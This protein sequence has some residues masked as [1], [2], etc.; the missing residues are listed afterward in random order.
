M[1]DQSS[2]SHPSG[3]E[4]NSIR[5]RRRLMT[6][7]LFATLACMA[8]I[9]L[10]IYLLNWG[11][12][13]AEGIYMV[14]GGRSFIEIER[15]PLGGLHVRDG[16]L[17]DLI[18]EGENMKVSARYRFGKLTIRQSEFLKDEEFGVPIKCTLALNVQLVPSQKI[19]GDWDMEKCVFDSPIKKN[20]FYRLLDDIGDLDWESFTDDLSSIFDTSSLEHII[21]GE[22]KPGVAPLTSFLHRL[23]DPR[24]VEYFNARKQTLTNDECLDILLSIMQDHPDDPYLMPHLVEMS[25]RSGDLETAQDN[26]KRWEEMYC[27]HPDP[28]LQLWAETAWKT[29]RY[30]VWRSSSGQ[31]HYTALFPKH[32]NAFVHNMETIEKWFAKRSEYDELIFCDMPLVFP[33]EPWSVI[34]SSP[35]NNN[36]ALG[37]IVK[38]MRVRTHYNLLQGDIDKALAVIEGVYRTMQDIESQNAFIVDR[39]V[40][41]YHKYELSTTLQD[42][43]LNAT[44]DPEEQRSIIAS[45]HKLSDVRGLAS[46]ESLSVGRIWTMD[47]IMDLE[48][49]WLGYI[50]MKNI[51]R[52]VNDS[53]LKII[54]DAASL[55]LFYLEH[56]AWPTSAMLSPDPFRPEKS[57]V[58]KQKDDG[59]IIYSIGPDGKDDLGAIRFDQS[60]RGWD[61]VGDILIEIPRMRKYPFPA[62]GVRA[63]N[64][65]ELLEQF[66][67]GLPLDPFSDGFKNPVAGG[68]T[69]PT[70]LAILDIPSSYPLTVFS[71]GPDAGFWA[72]LTLKPENR[73]EHDGLMQPVFNG[74]YIES[75]EANKL[76]REQEVFIPHASP[77]LEFWTPQVISWDPTNG[78]KSQGDIFLTIPKRTED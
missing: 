5:K 73:Q 12:G 54:R 7:A 53:R 33:D 75:A 40:A 8:A 56:D 20:F 55:R 39:G 29:M 6:A 65:E 25:A 50:E 70:A 15:G 64:A 63:D 68:F 43:A 67:N 22:L 24:V 28:I 57:F 11:S 10:I 38:A 61:S 19:R 32:P 14:N 18:I 9:P 2:G 52:L 71:I 30:Y 47:V 4:S 76:A 48:G 46:E 26:W 77:R 21:Q 42:L 17:H 23:D 36:F 74:D 37:E 60:E 41:I 35:V 49:I 16:L 34:A 13:A 45:L 69:T 51:E 78:T 3:K 31:M 59:L 58:L 27:N 72:Y 1:T 66:P 44:D 62:D